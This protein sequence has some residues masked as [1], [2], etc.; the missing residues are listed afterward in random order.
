[1][2]GMARG[3]SATRTNSGALTKKLSGPN[4]HRSIA[5]DA[6]CGSHRGA[7]RNG[8]TQVSRYGHPARSGPLVRRAFGASGMEEPRRGNDADASRHRRGSSIK[9]AATLSLDP[10]SRKALPQT[11]LAGR[12]TR[13]YFG[14]EAAV[15]QIDLSG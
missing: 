8:V 4:E 9:C 5:P 12:R 3:L 2:E 7:R 6:C 1:M 15:M 10:F 14:R 11:W 13:N